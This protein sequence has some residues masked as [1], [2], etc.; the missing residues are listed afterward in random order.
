M[1]PSISA[2]GPLSHRPRQGRACG[3]RFLIPARRPIFFASFR[4]VSPPASRQLTSRHARFRLCGFFQ[5]KMG[6]ETGDAECFIGGDAQVFGD[7]GNGFWGEMPF[8]FLMRDQR[9]NFDGRPIC[10]GRVWRHE[11]A[12]ANCDESGEHLT[13]AGS[14]LSSDALRRDGLSDAAIVE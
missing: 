1:R 12:P 3:R 10:R 7:A 6:E 14:A 9:L 13:R 5:V 11:E 2:A 4:S 8:F